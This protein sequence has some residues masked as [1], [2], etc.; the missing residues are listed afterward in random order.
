MEAM[1]L[2]VV[3][4][5]SD[6]RQWLMPLILFCSI[7]IAGAELEKMLHGQIDDKQER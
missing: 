4:A 7:I 2:Y 3:H 6:N 1:F 5:L